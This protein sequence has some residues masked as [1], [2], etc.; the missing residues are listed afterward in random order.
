MKILRLKCYSYVFILMFVACGDRDDAGVRVAN[1]MLS[2][3]ETG[4]AAPASLLSE[5]DHVLEIPEAGTAV[6]KVGEMVYQFDDLQKCEIERKGS[7]EVFSAFGT[8][9]LEDG[10]RSEFEMIRRVNNSG[11][12]ASG[13]RHERDFV[14]ISVHVSTPGNNLQSFWLTSQAGSR[15]NQPGDDVW[16]EYGQD[17]LLPFI[18]VKENS[19]GIM[20]TAVANLS[21][22]KI[23][24]EYYDGI[25]LDKILGEGKTEL[26]V[27]CNP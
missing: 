20:A 8:G 26:A 1:S 14:R 12:I 13:D 17:N 25:D 2:E 15:R 4:G 3:Q 24:P 18:Y 27:V 22:Q 16:M 6:I 10:R 9:N 23:V 21:R 11:E 7:V 5:T 19:P